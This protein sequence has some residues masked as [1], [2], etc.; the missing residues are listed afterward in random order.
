MFKTK[1]WGVYFLAVWLV[2]F[3]SPLL[4]QDFADFFVNFIRYPETQINHIRLPLKTDNALIR[5]NKSY[6]PVNFLTRNNIPILCSDSL[7][8]IMKTAEPL[9]SI[10][11]F[12]KESA[13]DYTFEQK[14][15][16]WKLAAFKNED[17]QNLR[18]A[19][20]LNFLSQYSKDESFQMKHTIFPFPYRTYKSAKKDSDPENKLLMPREW[21]ALDFTAIFP[22]I[23]IFNSDNTAPNRQLFVYRIGKIAQFF[24]FIQINKKWYLIEIEEYK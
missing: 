3:S 17:I 14:D 6:N 4:G 16:S 1:K 19:D 13:V 18:D 22:S 23:C 2:N 20:F 21:E 11:Q 15:K 5:S 7:N 12:N 9:V 24:N 8:A 10:I